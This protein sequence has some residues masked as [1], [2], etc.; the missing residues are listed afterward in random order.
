MKK[1]LVVNTVSS[2]LD[3][4][5]FKIMYEY[6]KETKDYFLYDFVLTGNIEQE[7]ISKLESIGNKFFVYRDFRHKRPIKYL[8]WLNGLLLENKYDI[9]HVHGNSATMLL[10]MYAAKANGI[11]KRICH[12]HSSSSKFKVIHNLLKP[13]LNKTVTSAVACSQVAG[14]WLFTTNFS[15]LN[16]GISSSK[17]QF[18]EKERKQYRELLKIEDSFVIGH[19]GYI[20]DEKNQLFLIDIVECLINDIPNIKLLL[21]GGGNE[22][23]QLK[24]IIKNKKLDD[25]IITLGRRNDVPRLYSAMDLFV[26]PSKFE[27]FGLVLVEAQANGLICLSSDNVP[28]ETAIDNSTKY[29]SLSD[30]NLWNEEIKS[31]SINQISLNRKVISQANIDVICKKHFDINT[32]RQKLIDLY[33]E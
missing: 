22:L 10:E 11:D 21:I 3:N 4:G 30:M 9:I 32:N 26:F 16:N 20:S 7:A 5:I 18:S 23:P 24:E 17:Y 6:A 13:A 2:K 19:V 27:G 25:Y 33:E 31:I 15:I 8:K 29:L 28:K 12:C 14:E 1:V